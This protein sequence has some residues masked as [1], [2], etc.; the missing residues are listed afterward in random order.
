M[1]WLSGWG[2]DRLKLTL[3]HTKIDSDQVDFPV[4]LHISAS[5][6][7]GSVDVSDVFDKLTSDAN[8]KKIAV[9]TSGGV[10]QCYVEIERWDDANEQ[11]WLWM[12]APALSSA[13]D[14][15]FYQYYDPAQAD[16]TTYI[17]D[18]GDTPAQS[19]WDSSFKLVMHM[20]QDPNGDVADA[21]KDSTSNAN[22]GTP[23]GTMLT[24]DLVDGKIGKGIDF[25]GTDDCVDIGDISMDFGTGGLTLEAIIKASDCATD[26]E[27][28]F[29]QDDLNSHFPIVYLRID[30]TGHI[31]FVVRGQTNTASKE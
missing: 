8:R 4:M 27:I 15:V 12:K 26:R 13:A 21:I 29:R 7:I 10:T 28:I 11:A 20:A 6:G 23:G 24:E 18:T 25:E 22:H 1:A 19:V 3:D 30:S 9:T 31:K 14:P 2:Q 17:G 5:S 16:N